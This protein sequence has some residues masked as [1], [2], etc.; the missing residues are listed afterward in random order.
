MAFAVTLEPVQDG[1][2]AARIGVT[3]TP[4]ERSTALNRE[5]KTTLSEPVDDEQWRVLGEGAV[6]RVVSEL[7]PSRITRPAL[8]MSAWLGVPPAPQASAPAPAE[9]RQPLE[10][11]ASAALSLAGVEE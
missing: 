10:L 5:F 7:A 4:R 3:V 9:D 8:R 1:K 6:Y 2:R 11:R